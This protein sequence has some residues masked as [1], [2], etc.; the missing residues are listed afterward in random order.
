MIRNIIIIGNN[1]VLALTTI[2]TTIT[3]K[4]IKKITNKTKKTI[5]WKNLVDAIE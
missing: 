5:R 3:Q 2:A 4:K 1:A